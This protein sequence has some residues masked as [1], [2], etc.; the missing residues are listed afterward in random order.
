MV[1]SPYN[2]LLFHAS[3]FVGLNQLFNI[4]IDKALA[5]DSYWIGAWLFLLPLFWEP[6][7]RSICHP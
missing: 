1:F 2:L 5:V 3:C 4:E 6:H 7:I